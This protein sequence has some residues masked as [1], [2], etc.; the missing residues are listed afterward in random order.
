VPTAGQHTDEVLSRVLG[1]GAAEVD[2]LRRAGA[3]G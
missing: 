2:A 3:I 1:Y